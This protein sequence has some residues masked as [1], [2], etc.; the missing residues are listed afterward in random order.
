MDPLI[1]L[2]GLM[3]TLLFGVIFF[4]LSLPSSGPK[5]SLKK[6]DGTDFIPTQMLMGNDG[7]GGIAVNEQSQRVCLLKTPS[8]SPRLFPVSGL[9][10]S[11]LIHNGEI[12][13]QGLRSFPKEVQTFI[14]QIQPKM[15]R[16]IAGLHA[17]SS[18]S[19]NQQIDLL[20]LVHDETEPIHV[21]NVLDMETK[22]GGIIFDK[23][24]NT[25]KHWHNVLNGLILQGDHQAR[26][27]DEGEQHTTN[28]SPTSV[29]DELVKLSDLL[30]KKLITKHE[31][32]SQKDKLLA[33]KP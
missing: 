5:E 32:E 11:H 2:F 33:V 8:S 7:L 22:K 4:I 17:N 18:S 24:I 12:I 30:D 13:D 15:H 25:A 3:V 19:I 9:L 14:R 26:L 29:A 1:I 6:I 16:E 28:G 27:E 31:F 21:V 20:I 10:G 23:A